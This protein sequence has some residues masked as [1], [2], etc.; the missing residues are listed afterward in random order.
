MYLRRIDAVV[1]L[2]FASTP[3]AKGDVR[4][5]DPRLE[6]AMTFGYYQPPTATDSL[7]HYYF[8][9][10]KLSGRRLLTSAPLEICA[11]EDSTPGGGL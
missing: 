11:S 1:G 2:V 8:N 3:R 9:G 7:G 10:S 6:G 5:L 4:R